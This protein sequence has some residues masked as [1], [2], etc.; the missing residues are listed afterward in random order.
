MNKN[1]IKGHLTDIS[2]S[3]QSYL[4]HPEMTLNTFYRYLDDMGLKDEH[5]VYLM[6]EELIDNSFFLRDQSRKDF[7]GRFDNSIHQRDF[8]FKKATRFYREPFMR[9]DMI[10]LRYV[11]SGECIIYTHNKK[12]ILKE[13]DTILMNCGFVVSQHLKHKEDNVFTLIFKR[14]YIA[15]LIRKNTVTPNTLTKILFDYIH[16]RSGSQS[17]MIFHGDDN[18][19]IKDVI[20][21]MICEYIDPIKAD[22][23]FLLENYLNIFMILLANSKCETESTNYQDVSRIA[24]MLNYIN[25]NYRNVTLKT[26]SDRYGYNVNYI[27]RMFKDIVGVS[28]KDYVFKKKYTSFMNSL[29]NTETSI[30]EIL[31]K[32]NISSETYF[33]RYFRKING[34]S[35][36][37]YRKLK[38][39][40]LKDKYNIYIK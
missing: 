22:G 14:N 40:D 28:F 9:A 8:I 34:V 18:Q 20:D 38:K 24:G 5:G 36:A 12:I 2:E 19:M 3:E 4:L 33:F 39:V 13:N 21:G 26:L 10:A 27:S 31:I 37:E 29:I 15:E 11:Y 1:E 16:N 30:Q 35:P 7:W 6:P 17:Y 25:I 32:E 23:S